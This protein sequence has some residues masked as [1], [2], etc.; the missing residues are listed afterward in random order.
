MF[1]SFSALER[2]RID[3]LKS[4]FVFCRERE[5]EREGP[6]F[7]GW[8]EKNGSAFQEGR[9][10]RT[11]T[12]CLIILFYFIYILVSFPSFNYK[13]FS[14][15]KKKKTCHPK[16]K[17]LKPK[18]MRERGLRFDKWGRAVQWVCREGGRHMVGFIC[19]KPNVN[20]YS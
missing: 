15:K 6:C 8:K 3:P 20:I 2:I 5:R 14:E 10:P 7:M 1:L 18:W 13:T 4:A 16:T 9:Q 17:N 12:I 11:A 19:K